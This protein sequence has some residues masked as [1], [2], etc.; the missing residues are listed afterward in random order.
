MGRGGVVSLAGR[1]ERAADYLD[2]N[3]KARP[4]SGTLDCLNS[5]WGT[6]WVMTHFSA[7][8]PGR[9]LIGAP[10][11]GYTVGKHGKIG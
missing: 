3:R 1:G 11:R 6:R 4:F 9:K 10:G 2:S 8:P 7:R 5:P